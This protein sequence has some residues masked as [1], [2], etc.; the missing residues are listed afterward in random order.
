MVSSVNVFL[1]IKASSL[2]D[3]GILDRLRKTQTLLEGLSV[4]KRGV[5]SCANKLAWYF[6][7]SE[8][9]G[10]QDKNHFSLHVLAAVA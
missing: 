7:N 8:S 1:S 9:S 6:V 2:I 3:L 10:M 5:D 4:K